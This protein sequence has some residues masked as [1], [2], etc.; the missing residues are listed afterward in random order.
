MNT[1]VTAPTAFKAMRTDLQVSM[2]DVVSAFVSH[3][4]N[5]LYDR[6]KELGAAIKV[7]ED[8]LKD[9]NKTILSKVTGDEFNT[10]L[11]LGLKA[12]V[13][14]GSINWSKS[15][16]NF[17]IVI[18]EVSKSQRYNNSITLSKSK[19]I[20]AAQVKAYER[21][22]K[23]LESLRSDLSEVLVALKSVTRKERQVR[24]RIA[25]RKLEDSG[26]ASL[27]NDDELVKLVQ[28]DD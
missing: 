24:G 15:K 21:I 20:P 25:M 17:Q 14:E 1:A 4:E 8:A 23:E 7:Q 12:T 10:A 2:D 9:N 5:N 19:A 28:L 27:M 22:T 6:K 3:Y 13:S 16:V 18:E 26:Y 11:P